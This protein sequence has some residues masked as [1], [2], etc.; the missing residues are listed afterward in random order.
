MTPSIEMH[1]LGKKYLIYRHPVDRL[2]ES[3]WWG[4]RCYHQELWALRDVSLEIQPGE[5]IGFVG[6][7]GAGKSTLLKLISGISRPTEGEIQVR[8]RVSA[9]MELGAGF[10]A[11][12]TGRENIYMNCSILGMNR[13]EIDLKL[14]E[15][16]DFAELGDF[17]DRPIKN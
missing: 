13:R 1:R 7:N 15:I 16:I 10:H 5:S 17:I 11:D 4:R 8:G 3:L 2:K 6:S 14:S 12:F 9:L